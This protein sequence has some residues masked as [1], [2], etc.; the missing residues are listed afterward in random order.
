MDVLHVMRQAASA[1]KKTNRNFDEDQVDDLVN[2]LPKQHT[3]G[4]E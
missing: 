4:K 2:D 3:V 1:L